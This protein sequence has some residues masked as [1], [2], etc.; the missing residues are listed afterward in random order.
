VRPEKHLRCAL[1]AAA[2]VVHAEDRTVGGE[3][4]A[5]QALSTPCSLTEITTDASVNWSGHIPSTR[6]QT[7]VPRPEEVVHSSF[8]LEQSL[9]QKIFRS[10]T[11]GGL[12]GGGAEGHDAGGPGKDIHNC[13]DKAV[14]VP[15]ELVDTDTP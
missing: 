14:R 6:I 8:L 4:D 7:V 1:G 9:A 5:L 15:V 12:V 11:R 3:D 2:L 10:L 13:G